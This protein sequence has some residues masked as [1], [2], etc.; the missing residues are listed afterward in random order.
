MLGY[1]AYALRKPTYL[2]QKTRKIIQK[3]FF[4]KKC[5]KIFFINCFKKSFNILEEQ[6]LK[7]FRKKIFLRRLQTLWRDFQ[8]L[9]DIKVFF[10]KKE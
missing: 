6:F 10:R 5:S 4:M 8:A 1:L 3:N 9:V 7:T 2:L